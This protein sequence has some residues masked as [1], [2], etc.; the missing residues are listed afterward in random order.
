MIAIALP[1]PRAARLFFI[2]LLTAGCH[3]ISVSCPPGDFLTLSDGI[4]VHPD[5]SRSGNT[6]AV[7]LQVVSASIIRVVASPEHDLREMKSLMTSYSGLARPKW[8]VEEKDKMLVLKTDSV[9]ASIS[10]ETGAVSFQDFRGNPLVSEKDYGG[11]LFTPAVFDGEL[12]YHIRQVF[13]TRPGESLYGL[14]QHQE[15][16]LN[17]N[18]RQVNLFQN[19]SEIAVPFLLSD[20]HYGILL[21]NYSLTSAGDTRPFLPLSRLKLFSKQGEEGFLTGSFINVEQ[22]REKILLS[23]PESSV[24]LVYLN[25]DRQFFPKGFNA[26]K[27]TYV[28]EGSIASSFTGIHQFKFIYGGYI[29]VW[30]NGKELLDRWRQAWNPANAILDLPLEKDQK[31]TLRIEWKPDGDESYLSATWL[32]PALPGM[33]NDYAFSS[34]AGRQLD[35]YLVYGNSMDAII[36]GYRLLTG[37]A[38]MAPRWA[39]GLW[40]S[41]ERYKSEQELLNT[42]SEFRKRK[43][44]LDNIVLDWSYW[45]LNA[46]GSQEFD[47]A[48]FPS[49][50]SMIDQIHRDHCHFMISVWPKFYEGITAYRMFND[51]GWL[52]KRNIADRQQDWKGF[53]STFYDAFNPAAR[54]G[55]WD[56]I[57]EKLY[58]KGVD[59]FWM[60]ASEPDILGNASPERR[61][62]QMTPTALGPAAAY[63]NAYPLENTKGVYEGQRA[64][65]PDKRVF[66]LTRS[67][68]AGSQHY[69]AAVWS[70][71]IAARWSD[72]KAQ[73]TAGINFSLSGI[74]FWTMDIGGFAVEHRYEHAQGEDLEEWRE[75]M[76]RWYQFGAFCPLFRVHGQFPYREIYNVAPE[77]HPAYQSMLY[78]DKLRYRLMPYLYT[79]N[80]MT[81]HQDYTIMRGLVM[82]FP[83]D[84]IARQT[85]D[86]YM[87]GPSLLV[88][89]V[90]TFKARSREV[91]LPS[92]QGWYDLYSGNYV[93][94]GQK[95]AAAAPYGRMPVYVKEGSIL[96]FGPELQYSSEKPAD[97][98]N[99]FVY[100]GRDAS[101]SLYED[102]NGN[103]DY[104]KGSF[105]N[106]LFRYDESA[107]TLTIGKREGSFPGMLGS[108]TFRILLI[109][110]DRPAGL[111]F[112][113]ARALT[114][115]YNGNQ[116]IIR[117][118]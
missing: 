16:I 57:N 64:A 2:F 14:G 83:D 15:G 73:I 114:V 98:V 76:T 94:G 103:Y 49:P 77:H 30:F 60:D 36:R 78:Y 38:T 28:L 111:D 68:Y 67:A 42:V 39:L 118:K 104:E 24:N 50:D 71:D 80:G 41:R 25:D 70:G 86:Q 54:K 85:G 27:G 97:P 55:F 12:F 45:K 10:T 37:K 58:R 61:K 17:I 47:P 89:P 9:S 26:T 99:L 32:N 23:R 92:G 56:L 21:D 101:F 8:T 63:L 18:H 75:Q 74:P 5:S 52:Y 43:I 69:G 46:W 95:I 105:A 79:L 20:R 11:R 96:P 109:T 107:K 113:S 19:N 4:V 88:S 66:I 40:Q 108:R 87:L 31:Y 53:V 117:L 7:K 93:N 81:Y 82:D 102:E 33:E 51:K 72:M 110:K 106:I 1:K 116:K 91:Y 90:Y 22:G 44:P 35:Y 13:H 100:G 29:K 112:A 3:F 48:F 115:R 65:D 62:E 6:K 34:E 84:S 59:A